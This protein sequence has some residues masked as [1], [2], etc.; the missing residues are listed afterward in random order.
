MKG[1][2][3]QVEDALHKNIRMHCFENDRSVKDYFT[4]L[5]ETDIKIDLKGLCYEGVSN[6][7]E[8]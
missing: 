7:E 3:F 1:I 5:A 2:C 4:K 6:S 8:S